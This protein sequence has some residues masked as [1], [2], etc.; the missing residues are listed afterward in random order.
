MCNFR[1]A[2]KEY[3]KYQFIFYRIVKHK[4]SENIEKF[5]LSF[6]TVKTWRIFSFIARLAHIESVCLSPH[7]SLPQIKLQ[8]TGY[9]LNVPVL[10]GGQIHVNVRLIWM[11]H[12]QETYFYGKWHYPKRQPKAEANYC[13]CI[14]QRHSLCG[15]V[16]SLESQ[17]M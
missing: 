11:N 16:G 4:K 15:F 12:N 1:A 7:R 5:H 17:N 10:A 3:L 9:R 6:K 8:C 2:I 13:F 14:K